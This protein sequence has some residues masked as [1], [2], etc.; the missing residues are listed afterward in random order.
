MPPIQNACPPSNENV[1][2]QSAEGVNNI[3]QQ[4]A[5]HPQSVQSNQPA[6]S[7]TPDTN[8]PAQYSQT[9]V[10]SRSSSPP[11]ANPSSESA[12]KSNMNLQTANYTS[13][14]FLYKNVMLWW[15]FIGFLWNKEN[16]IH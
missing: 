16:C 9:S 4:Q 14:F 3:M 15:V 6:S 12:E 5:V 10:T 11:N 13:E 7:G 2:T 8:I 1:M